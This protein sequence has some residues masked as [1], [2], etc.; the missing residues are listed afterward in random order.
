[1]AELTGRLASASRRLSTS[2]KI[3]N[4][5]S[6]TSGKVSGSIFCRIPPKMSVATRIANMGTKIGR[7]DCLIAMISTRQPE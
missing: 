4:I 6:N 1:M 2:Q 7:D 5:E 3:A